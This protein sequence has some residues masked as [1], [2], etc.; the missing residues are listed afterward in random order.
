M[1]TLPFPPRNEKLR[2]NARFVKALLEGLANL[3][4]GDKGTGINEY[5]CHAVN[6]PPLKREI[7]RRL[8][9][10]GTYRTWVERKHDGV[11]FS[12]EELQDGR[13]RWMLDMIEEFSNGSGS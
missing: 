8:R 2:R 1:Q 9:G 5:I 12:T 4:D 3:W 13:R 10:C 11:E 6:Y 7:E